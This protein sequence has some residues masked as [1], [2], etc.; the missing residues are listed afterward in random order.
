MKFKFNCIN[1]QIELARWKRFRWLDWSISH[2]FWPSI[3]TDQIKCLKVIS[4]FKKFAEHIVYKFPSEEAIL[5]KK[6]VA[7][8]EKE[9][10]TKKKGKKD[11]KS[12]KGKI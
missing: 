4:N 6:S 10:K 7:V 12:S 1:F 3:S 2:N 5:I 9:V 8:L 11:K